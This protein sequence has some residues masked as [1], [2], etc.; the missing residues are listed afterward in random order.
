MSR[1]QDCVE[2]LVVTQPIPKLDPSLPQ[3]EQ[4]DTLTLG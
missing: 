3:L 2:V 1:L 4:L